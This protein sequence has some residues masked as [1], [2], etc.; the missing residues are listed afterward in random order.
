MVHQRRR[1][2]LRVV[3]LDRVACRAADVR[4][5]EGDA[6]A[7]EKARIRR[8]ADERRRGQ[9]AGRRGRRRN[10]QRRRAAYAAVSRGDRDAGVRVDGRRVDAEG[11][12]RG[13]RRDGDAGRH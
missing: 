8:G 10:G 13:A 1:E 6:R 9:R 12:T 2:G 3:Y 4:P 11:R 5:V 7:R